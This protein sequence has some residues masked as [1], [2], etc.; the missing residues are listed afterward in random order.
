MRTHFVSKTNKIV[1]IL[2]QTLSLGQKIYVFFNVHPMVLSNGQLWNVL[3][4]LCVFF[5]SMLPLRMKLDFFSNKL[6]DLV[7]MPKQYLHLDA[8]KMRYSDKQFLYG[9][10]LI[11]RPIVYTFI[12][13]VVKVHLLGYLITLYPITL[14]QP[15]LFYY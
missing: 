12:F 14:I 2:I 8:F 9:I 10:F 5:W 6:L 3:T 7:D 1:N 11:I 4:P 13:N 15:C